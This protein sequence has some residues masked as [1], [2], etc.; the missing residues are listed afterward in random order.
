MRCYWYFTGNWRGFHAWIHPLSFGRHLQPQTVN[1]SVP[2]PFSQIDQQKIAKTVGKIRWI[3]NEMLLY[4]VVYLNCSTWSSIHFTIQMIVLCRFC[5]RKIN[6]REE[7]ET[8]AP[9]CHCKQV[10]T[11]FK[12]LN[13]N[14]GTM[15]QNHIPQLIQ[16]WGCLFRKCQY[17]GNR[18]YQF[19]WY[20]LCIRT[21]YSKWSLTG[22]H[23]HLNF[24][25]KESENNQHIQGKWRTLAIEKL[26]ARRSFLVSILVLH[27]WKNWKP[28]DMEKWNYLKWPS[29]W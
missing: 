9:Y 25:I 26:M 4:N 7:I 18:H 22:M 29:N 1:N 10:T 5:I 24:R 6:R 27:W 14:T 20:N 2:F 16:L 3:H 28:T 8:C 23:M 15:S 12:V 11:K 21:V 19:N 13:C 17:N